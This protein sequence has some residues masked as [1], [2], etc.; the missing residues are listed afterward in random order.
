MKRVSFTGRS[1]FKVRVSYEIPKIQAG[2]KKNILGKVNLS[3]F[4]LVFVLLPTEWAFKII[5][6]TVTLVFKF[7]LRLLELK[8]VHPKLP[9]L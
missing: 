9:S 5:N 7:V 4:S 3:L 6:L 8:L 2:E 1:F